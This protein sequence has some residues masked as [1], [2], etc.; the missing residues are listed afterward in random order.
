MTKLSS[1]VTPSLLVSDMAATLAFYGELGFSVTGRQ[2]YGDGSWVEVSRGN[3]ALQFFTDPPAGIP[4][5]PVMSGTLYFYPENV[6]ALAAEWTGRVAFAWGPEL[7]PYGMYEFGIV[8][9]NGYYLAFTQPHA[10]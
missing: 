5:S 6:D 8:D 10:E 4:E 2:Q 9:P 1:R 7:M 3:V